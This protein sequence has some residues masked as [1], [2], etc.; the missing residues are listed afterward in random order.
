MVV[1]EAMAHGLPV[2]VSGPQHCGVSSQLTHGVQAILLP[3]PKDAKHLAEL[4]EAV[5]ETPVLAERLR[6]HGLQFAE[7]HSWERAALQY[8]QLYLQ[9]GS[10]H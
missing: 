4:I 5:L 3:D 9:T 6:H 7:L 10:R 8:E 1:L 2:V